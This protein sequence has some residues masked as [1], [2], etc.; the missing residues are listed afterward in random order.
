MNELFFEGH[1]IV[2][3]IPNKTIGA[4]HQ[5]E[6]A[7]ARVKLQHRAEAQGVKLVSSLDDLAGDLEFTADF[8]VEEFL[9][10]VHRDRGRSR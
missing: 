6:M 9:R 7:E 1:W 10:Q 3:T 5:L 4:D 8:D 2:A